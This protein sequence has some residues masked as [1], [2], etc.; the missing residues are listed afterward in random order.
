MTIEL[1]RRM[2]SR[3]P[4]PDGSDDPELAELLGLEAQER[5]RK[6]GADGEV[7]K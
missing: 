6:F 3:T 5:A 7:N 4:T 2:D 1:S